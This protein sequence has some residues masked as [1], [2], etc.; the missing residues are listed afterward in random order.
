MAAEA[1][2]WPRWLALVVL[3]PV[4]ALGAI[5][6]VLDPAGRIDFFL[7]RA[8]YEEVVQTM[9]ARPEGS[10]GHVDQATFGEMVVTARHEGAGQHTIALRAHDH[11]H[12]G[13]TGYLYSDTL[14][15]RIEGDPDFAAQAPDGPWT[16]GKQVAPHWWVVSNRL[17]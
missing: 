6:M 14:L 2:R 7:H 15:R 10:A 13:T 5:L 4:V 12:A 9:K 3:V 8:H 17:D 1:R 11:G 16:L